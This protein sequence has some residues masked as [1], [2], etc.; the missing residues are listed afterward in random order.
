MTSALAVPRRSG[1]LSRVRTRLIERMAAIDSAAWD[2]LVGEDDP[3]VEHAFLRTLEDSGSASPRAGWS[4]IHVTVWDGERLVGALPLYA[5]D[6]SY[7]EYIFDWAWA[8]AA[9]RLGIDYYPKLVSMVPVTPATGRRLLIAE[10]APREAV[11][12]ALSRGLE[13][14]AEVVN[15]SSIHVLFL[16]GQERE[17]MDRIARLRPRLSY[18]YHWYNE[19]YRTFDDYLGRFRSSLRK[20]LRRERREV[21][22]SGLEIRTMGG[23]ELDREE[24]KALERF[25]RGTC[26][27]H[28]SPAYLTPRF[29]DLCRERLAHRVVSV[30]AFAKGVPVAGSLN[31]EKG[32]HLYGR[33]WG[34]SEDHAFLHFEL[35]YYRLI[36]RAIERGMSRFEAGAQGDHKLRRGLLPRAVHSMHWVRHPLLSSAIEEY[37]P[38]EAAVVAEEMQSL[39]YAGPFR[40][41]GDAT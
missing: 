36:E 6:H 3:F 18:Q 2:A 13:E 37:L 14:A 20:Q 4:P 25:Y 10:D 9:A 28:G 7:G 33:Y 16:T 24:W 19:G 29:F 26:A 1:N 5:K 31:F 22:E 17:A 32:R 12:D 21:A 23:E 15:A 30:M 38:R 8:N 34:C 41:E 27:A 40:R 35:C 11:V 39:T